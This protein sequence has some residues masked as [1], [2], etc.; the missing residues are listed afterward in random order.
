[1][2]PIEMLE[3]M[4]FYLDFLLVSSLLTGIALKATKF[5]DLSRVMF[6]WIDRDPSMFLEGSSTA[7]GIVKLVQ[8]CVE[9][10]QSAWAGAA[11]LE[12]ALSRFT[13]ESDLDDLAQVAV[14][15]FGFSGE[16]ATLATK[17]FLSKANDRALKALGRAAERNPSSVAESLRQVLN[18]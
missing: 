10:R 18:Q 17:L 3:L 8:A 16:L 1:M 14:S 12:G 7:S 2:N 5:D 4:C 13:G 11:L 15:N 9:S 6:T